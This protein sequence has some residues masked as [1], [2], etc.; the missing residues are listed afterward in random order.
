MSRGLGLQEDLVLSG[1]Q[2][3]NSLS[4]F[5]ENVINEAVL[6]AARP[7]EAN[8]VGMKARKLESLQFQEEMIEEERMVEMPAFLYYVTIYSGNS[9]CRIRKALL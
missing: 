4:S 3:R 8:T 7:E 9:C 5:D 6:K 2:L 1:E